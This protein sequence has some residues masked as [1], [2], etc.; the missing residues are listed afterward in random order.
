MPLPTKTSNANNEKLNLSA[1]EIQNKM[2]AAKKRQAEANRIERE[3][4]Y[5]R[6]MLNEAEEERVKGRDPSTYI[7]TII[8]SLLFLSLP[9]S[10]P[11][12]DWVLVGIYVAFGIVW[13]IFFH[14]HTTMHYLL[15][16]L[17]Q[18][19]IAQFSEVILR[20]PSI[21]VAISPAVYAIVVV[22]NVAFNIL[23]YRFYREKAATRTEYADWVATGH[24]LL[25]LA[26][27]LVTGTIPPSALLQVA[28][29]FLKLIKNFSV[30]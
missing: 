10:E 5:E 12:V 2:A 8:I 24:I 22:V 19:L 7:G 3:K 25:N 20:L 29:S 21:A 27:L 6:E 18:I 1:S 14:Q 23:F 9:L 16:C 4:K 28:N 13:N 15:Y 30:G 11:R 17:L 26:L